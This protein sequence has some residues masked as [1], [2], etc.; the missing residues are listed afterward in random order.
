MLAQPEKTSSVPDE[1]EDDRPGDDVL[2][3]VF[4]FWLRGSSA[5][6][7]SKNLPARTVDQI[8]NDIKRSPYGGRKRLGVDRRRQFLG[9][10]LVLRNQLGS[11]MEVKSFTLADDGGKSKSIPAPMYREVGC[12]DEVLA[13]H[14]GQMENHRAARKAL[15]R[16]NMPGRDGRPLVLVQ[17]GGVGGMV[18]IGSSLFAWLLNKGLL[19]EPEGVQHPINGAG[20][21]RKRMVEEFV[22]EHEISAMSPL[23]SPDFEPRV[24]SGSAEG[25]WLTD[26]QADAVKRIGYWQ[27]ARAAYPA[28]VRFFIQDAVTPVRDIVPEVLLTIDAIAVA[29][30]AV[31]KRAFELRWDIAGGTSARAMSS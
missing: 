12:L 24:D 19:G 23:G 28:M 7:I 8:K 10:L 4:V 5:A 25:V 1:D 3:F 21:I 15:K 20:M 9:D 29:D 2:Y 27:S 17:Q 6:A 30:R 16:A 18:D 22:A 14:Y 11:Y 13:Q 26:R 31:T